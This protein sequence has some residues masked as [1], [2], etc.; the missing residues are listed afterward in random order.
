MRILRALGRFLRLSFEPINGYVDRASRGDLMGKVFGALNISLVALTALFTPITP[1][2]QNVIGQIPNSVLD[3]LGIPANDPVLKWAGIPFVAILFM[4]IAGTKALMRIEDYETPW[5]EIRFEFPG[6]KNMLSRY[7]LGFPTA[8][9]PY[10]VFRLGV[11]NCSKKRVDG[12]T[13][14]IDDFRVTG[15]DAPASVSL[16]YPL[17][18]IDDSEDNAGSRNGRTIP[19]SEEPLRFV[20]FVRKEYSPDV[21]EPIPYADQLT[22]CHVKPGVARYIPDGSWD[23]TVIAVTPDGVGSRPKAYR[24]ISSQTACSLTVEPI[25]D[26]PPRQVARRSSSPSAATS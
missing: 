13:V 8:N 21:R 17:R 24:V 11:V 23:F 15:A 5:V 3:A 6:D 22:I 4:L 9:P 25:R 19:I 1:F 14:E 26:Y 12:V 16:P 10:E 7:Y 18:Y 2:W 20:D